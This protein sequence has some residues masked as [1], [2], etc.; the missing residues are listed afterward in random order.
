[1]TGSGVKVGVITWIS[2][3]SVLESGD[4]LGGKFSLIKGSDMKKNSRGARMK[5]A[6]RIAMQGSSTISTCSFCGSF[7]LSQIFFRSFIIYLRTFPFCVICNDKIIE[8]ALGKVNYLYIA[9][10]AAPGIIRCR[11]CIISIIPR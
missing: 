10:Q 4:G 3:R 1:M 11:L 5:P 8:E 9:K 2:T 6:V 7:I